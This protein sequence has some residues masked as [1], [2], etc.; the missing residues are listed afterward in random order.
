[1]TFSSEISF[2]VDI[3]MDTYVDPPLTDDDCDDFYDEETGNNEERL[4]H[5]VRV[6]DETVE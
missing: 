5:S 1:M 3:G 2:D 6:I 4:E